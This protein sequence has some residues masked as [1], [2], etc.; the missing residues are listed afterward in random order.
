MIHLHKDVPVGFRMLIASKIL[1]VLQGGTI[2]NNGAEWEIEKKIP[3]RGVMILSAP[4][5]PDPAELVKLAFATW[6]E[7]KC[8]WSSYCLRIEDEYESEEFAI[9]WNED[10]SINFC[11]VEEN[12]LSAY[13]DS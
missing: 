2:S 7:N 5:I 4:S 1:N 8:F 13:A 9:G 6:G 3:E 12:I 10:G 11:R